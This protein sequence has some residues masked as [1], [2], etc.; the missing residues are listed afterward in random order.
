MTLDQLKHFVGDIARPYCLIST[1]TATAWAI[2]DGKDAG[3]ITAAGAILLGL[4]GFRSWE[5]TRSRAPDQ[6]EG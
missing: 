6:P 4:Y 1:G 3:I 5:N 2:F